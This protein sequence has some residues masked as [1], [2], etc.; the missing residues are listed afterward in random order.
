ML[1]RLNIAVRI[2]LLLA[3]SALG[4]LVCAGIGLMAL[5]MQM[6]EEKRVQLRYVMDVVLNDARNDMNGAGGSQ[7]GSGRDGFLDVI[8]SAKFGDSAFNFFFV[9]DYNGVVIWHPDPSK[10]GV[11]RSN[12]VYPNGLKMIQKFIEGARGAPLGGYFDYDG[13]DNRGN[14][15]PKLT[16]C[17]DVP[18]LKF[19]VCVGID[20]KDVEIAFLD[21][22]YLMAWLFIVVMLAIGLA[23]V[24]ISRSIGEPLSNAV[25]KIK[26]LANGDLDIAPAN[27]DEKSELGEVDKALDVLRAN[28]IEQQALQ[29]KVREQTELLMRQHKE[30]EERWRQIRGGSTRLHAHARSQH[31]AC[32]LQP[33][34][35][36]TRRTRGW[37]YRK[38]PL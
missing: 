26:R 30:S 9:D 21:R 11:N 19:V 35:G 24:I 38:L 29:E 28:A 20:A 27:S 4:M 31:G 1:S 25:R 33:P 7:T 13:P 34:L 32:R 15:G 8:K 22:L 3:L 17:R 5:R 36:R 10:R 2:N 37:M 14:I 6:L 16:H 18:D 23:S 12:V